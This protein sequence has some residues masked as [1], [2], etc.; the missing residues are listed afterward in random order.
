MTDDQPFDELF[1]GV[2]IMAILRGNGV[3]MSVHLANTAWDLG[4][5]AVEVTLQ[6]DE[7]VDALRAIVKIGHARGHRVGAG[8]ILDADGVAAAAEA[9]AAFT[10]SPGLDLDLVRASERAGMPSLPGVSTP[11]EVQLA[12]AA[13]CRWLKA[14]PASALGTEWF[15]AIRGPF[16]DISFVAT[17]GI[18]SGNAVRF[19]DVGVK[20]VAVGSALADSR[21][22]PELAKILAR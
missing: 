7:D 5:R 15:Q 11:T 19:L 16:P 22:L 9:G 20:V 14:F 13:G 8:T 4:I 18:N 2:P 1:E 12:R 6:S 3:A 10:V 17:G 21:E